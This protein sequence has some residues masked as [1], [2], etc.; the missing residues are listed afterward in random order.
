MATGGSRLLR[1]L[2]SLSLN[3]P[4]LFVLKTSRPI[5]PFCSKC[6]GKGNPST[7]Q[8]WKRTSRKPWN[9]ASNFQMMIF[10]SCGD[11]IWTTW[12]NG[13]LTCPIAPYLPSK[14]YRKDSAG[15]RTYTKLSRKGRKYCS[16]RHW[17]LWFSSMSRSSWRSWP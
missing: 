2:Q 11:Y 9:G 6:V 13:W 10:T 7:W 17:R 15:S 8:F 4:S 14:K 3:W 12:T 1:G 5:P 16:S